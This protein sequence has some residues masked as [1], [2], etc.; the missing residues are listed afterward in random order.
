MS[1]KVNN[2]V[3]LK[4]MS[5]QW[6]GSGDRGFFT[7]EIITYV[8][9]YILTPTEATQGPYNPLSH[10]LTVGVGF[11][12]AVCCGELALRTQDTSD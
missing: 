1:P 6:G 4:H 12:H 3:Q 11:A 9:S 10:C 2:R 8:S 5:R 7:L